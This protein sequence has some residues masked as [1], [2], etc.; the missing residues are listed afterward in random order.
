M[1]GLV[2]KNIDRQIEV[3]DR[4]SSTWFWADKVL[5]A[6][7]PETGPAGFIVYC[8]L[9]TMAGNGDQSCWPS[10]PLIAK[11]T[12]IGLAT[13]KRAM[14]KL[15][16]A[17]MVSIGKKMTKEKGSKYTH[18]VNVYTLLDLK[19]QAQIDTVVQDHSVISDQNHRV[20]G[21]PGTIKDLDLNSPKELGGEKPTPPSPPSNGNGDLKDK[22]WTWPMSLRFAHIYRELLGI[23]YTIQRKTDLPAMYRLKG[24]DS[25][26]DMA[27]L[28]TYFIS[29]KPRPAEDRSAK[30]F[31][32]RQPRTISEFATRINTIRQLAAGRLP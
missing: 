25:D 18:P 6:R 14:K 24:S 31:L 30:G 23:P 2:L 17:G 8:F 26:A 27:K 5:F 16:A 10:Q 9:A 7:L 20:M 15:E 13:V 32:S 28:M 12:G 11:G 3:R 1:E 19:P 4:R 29:M 22:N 21:E